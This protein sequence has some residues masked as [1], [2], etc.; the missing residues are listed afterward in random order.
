MLLTKLGVNRCN[1]VIRFV[2]ATMLIAIENAFIGWPAAPDLD[3]CLQNKMV[4]GL[5]TIFFIHHFVFEKKI[6]VR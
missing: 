3:A 1:S 2:L 6:M 5:T 4:T